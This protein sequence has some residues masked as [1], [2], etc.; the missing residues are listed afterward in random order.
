MKKVGG[1][2][3]E[4]LVEYMTYKKFTTLKGLKASNFKEEKGR[5][6]KICCAN[7]SP[8][9]NF[10]NVT[11]NRVKLVYQDCWIVKSEK[12]EEIE[13]ASGFKWLRIIRRPWSQQT[14]EGSSKDLGLEEAKENKLQQEDCLIWRS[15][16]SQPLAGL[17]GTCSTYGKLHCGVGFCIGRY[18]GVL[19]VQSS[20]ANCR[21]VLT[22][23]CRLCE[24][25]LCIDVTMSALR[26]TTPY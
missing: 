13:D 10:G 7:R 1:I 6:Y 2:S 11:N 12:K 19:F 8:V 24:L 21:P 15:G 20:P 23:L 5:L 26:T 18:A 9:K 25:R 14:T 17:F 3:D 22:P 16:S 4:E